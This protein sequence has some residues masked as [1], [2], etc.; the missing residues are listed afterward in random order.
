MP[1]T[2]NEEKTLPQTS[3]A[4][5][6]AVKAATAGL[7]GKILHENIEGK[8]VNIQF[9]KT[10]HGQVL[11][12]RTVF[13]THVEF[14]DGTVKLVV[15]AFP[16]DAVGRKLMFGARKGVTRKVLDWFWAHIDHNLE[17]K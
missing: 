7:E 9:P 15:E 12:D 4:V 10:I 11:G 3:D 14:D 5:F 1:Y 6:L 13:N 8:Q 16:V 17:D 2:I